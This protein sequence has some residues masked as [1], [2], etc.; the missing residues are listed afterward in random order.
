MKTKQAQWVTFMYL[1]SY[2]CKYICNNNKEEKAINLRGSEIGTLEGGGYMGWKDLRKGG[3][4]KREG[5]VLNF[6]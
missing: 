6:N 3:L 1:C 2:I 4:R 5:D